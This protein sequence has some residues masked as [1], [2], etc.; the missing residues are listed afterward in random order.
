MP[1]IADKVLYDLVKQKA[2]EIYSKPSAYK[3]GWIVKT[4]KELGGRYLDDN[5]P[6]ALSRWF[7]EGWSDIGGLSY[8]VYRPFRRVSKATPLT[9]FEIDPE[10]SQKQILLKQVIKGD[11]NL[12]PFLR[13]KS[14]K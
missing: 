10:D 1:I 11:A 13:D 9:A 3:S 8:P 6:K 4:Y 14:G 2:D 12:P 7:K 5:K